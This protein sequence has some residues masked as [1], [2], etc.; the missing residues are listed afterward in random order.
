MQGQVKDP[1]IQ[2]IFDMV[3]ENLNILEQ[4]TGKS[5]GGKTKSETDKKED[6]SN[7]SDED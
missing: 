1:K 4:K 7:S 2:K 3:G 5:Y 6:E